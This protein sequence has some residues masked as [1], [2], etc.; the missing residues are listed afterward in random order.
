M[1]SCLMTLPL[2]LTLA[3]GGA[4]PPAA[5]PATVADVGPL[6]GAS[7]YQLDGVWTDQHG[8]SSTLSVLRG[9]P[10]L[11]AMVYTSCQGACP[12]IVADMK[13]V[14]GELGDRAG[15]VGFVLASIDPAHDTVEQLASFAKES[16]LDD[17][18]WTLLRAADADVRQLAV[19]IGMRVKPTGPTDF[20]HSNLITVLDRDG[21][22]VHQQEG[23][24]TDPGPTLAAIRAALDAR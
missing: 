18:R 11:V 20:A 16:S 13:R 22:V 12:R 7:V 9:Q 21:R 4:P 14:E 24:G 17:G 15:E 2:W 5:S 10:R 8:R 1:K 19:A 6:P 3:C 23:L